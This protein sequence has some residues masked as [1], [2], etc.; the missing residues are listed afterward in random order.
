MVN[1]W[2]FFLIPALRKGYL[3]NKD[4]NFQE[5]FIMG[6]HYGISGIC[7]P[8]LLSP[9]YGICYYFNLSVRI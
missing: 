3:N 1:V 6:M 9:Y 4:K 7:L 5:W 8:S 2:A